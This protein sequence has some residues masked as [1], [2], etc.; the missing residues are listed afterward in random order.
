MLDALPLLLQKRCLGALRKIC[1]RSGLVPRSIEIPPCYNR[2]DE[3]LYQGGY[4]DVWKGKHN[5]CDVA[6][7]GLRVFAGSDSGKIMRVGSIVCQRTFICQLM[8]IMVEVLQ[9]GCDLE[10]S[11]PPKRAT[12]IRS[13]NGQS[14]FCDGLRVDG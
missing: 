10:V 2:S 9:G 12:A 13:D 14:Q 7:K 4:A 1:G 11:S 5:G 8:F 3:P 6:V